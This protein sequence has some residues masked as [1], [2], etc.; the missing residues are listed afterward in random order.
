[1]NTTIRQG[2]SVKEALLQALA[3]EVSI[4]PGMAQEARDRFLS[5][6]KWLKRD[7]SIL[8]SADPHLH[9]QGSFL[10]GTVIRPLGDC[11]EVD[12]DMVCTLRAMLITAKTQADV[13][14]DV[15]LEARSYAEAHGMQDPKE[16]RRC[17]RLDYA[18]GARFHCDILASVPAAAT[19]GAL[20]LGPGLLSS[21]SDLSSSTLIG[22]TDRE[23]PDYNRF[24]S[25][26]TIADPKGYELWFKERQRQLLEDR[27]RARPMQDGIRA[28]VEELPLQDVRTPLQDAIKLLK[29]HRDQMFEGD[30]HKPI[31]III[32]A[33]LAAHAYGGQATIGETL[34]AVLPRM[35]SFI[36]DRD[37][38]AWVQNPAC[39]AENFADEWAAAPRKGENFQ[40]W[41]LQVQRDFAEYLRFSSADAIPVELRERMTETTVAKVLPRLALATPALAIA[42]A[43]AAEGEAG[44]RSVLDGEVRH[45][46]SEGQATKPWLPRP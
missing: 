10:L 34:S 17:W 19:R 27:L 26:W 31:S 22:I 11:D 43:A 39:P 36:E 35:A 25:S 45:V 28:T 44:L 40:T 6:A 8:A 2:Q 18:K 12:V 9:P 15:G 30:A 13:K 29:R 33:T 32:I 23:H 16:G 7:G 42:V 4:R 38:I 14:A 21:V 1:M 24:S 46:T 5:I 41:L 37:G 20:S 3:D